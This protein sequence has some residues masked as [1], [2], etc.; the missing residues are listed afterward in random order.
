MEAPGLL[1]LLAALVI[2]WLVGD[3][4]RVWSKIP[5][6]VVLFGTAISKIDDLL[7]SETDADRIRFNK[8]ALA[9][10]VLVFAAIAIGVL[11][12][13]LLNK[14]GI[15][16]WV[17]QVLIVSVFMAQR[18]L[19]EHV[20][21]VSTAMEEDGLEGARQAVSMIVGRNPKHLDNEGVSRAAIESLAENFSDGVVAPAFW[22]AVFGLPGLLA[23]KMINT[24]DSMIGYRSEKYLWF[25][26]A[27]AVLDDLANWL[28]ARLSVFLIA[29]GGGLA[30]GIRAGINAIRCAFRDAGLHR[31]PNAGWP[32]AA[33][34]GACDVALGGPRTYHGETVAQTWIN[35]AGTVRPD[36]GLIQQAVR[37]TSY[38]CFAIWGVT[39]VLLL[40]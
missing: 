40:L 26:K 3:P 19:I 31:S 24:A 20:L 8:G 13:Y 16:G 39:A 36:A 4:D 5:H 7:N 28:P 14:A 27:A 15:W 23:Y 9:V 21:A 22:Y 17:L 33:M 1:I 18:S 29:L 34:A 10:T 11:L 37:M 32:E 35:G 12:E 2:D 38:A 25:G 30:S 6:P